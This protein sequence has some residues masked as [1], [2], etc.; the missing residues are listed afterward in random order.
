MDKIRQ[1]THNECIYAH[2]LVTRVA[3]TSWQS[4]IPFYSSYFGENTD[5][6][7]NDC[8]FENIISNQSPEPLYKAHLSELALKQI[9]SFCC[10]H[11]KNFNVLDFIQ[12]MECFLFEFNNVYDFHASYCGI[13]SQTSESQI[14]EN[15]KTALWDFAFLC[16]TTNFTYFFNNQSNLYAIKDANSGYLICENGTIITNEVVIESFFA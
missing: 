11:P 9:W 12:H 2:S 1:L 8:E 16:G 10:S 14:P 13:F 5:I 15:N 6:N 4:L 3:T 7:C